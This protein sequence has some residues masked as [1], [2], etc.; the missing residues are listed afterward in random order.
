M[1]DETEF[2]VRIY[3]PRWGHEDAYRFELN[4]EQMRIEGV[5]KHALCSWVDNEDPR[6]TGHN[7]NLGHPLEKMLENDLVYPPTVF[8][9]AIQHAW[10]SWRDG[11][12]D[13]EQA[14]IEVQGL[15]DWLN[16]VTQNRP[17]TDYWRGVF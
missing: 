16:T 11:D 13:D 9:R 1:S 17:N 7:D 6:W 2:E 4:R 14:R 8:A 3:S 12:L 15:S 5:G 10:I